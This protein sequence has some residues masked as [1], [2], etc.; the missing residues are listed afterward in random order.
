LSPFR[1]EKNP[2]FSVYADDTRFHDY[3]TG[4]DGDVFDFYRLGV[5]CAARESFLALKEMVGGK[6][7]NARPI[8]PACPEERKE[9]YHPELTKPTEAD[10]EA[11]SSLRLISVIGLDI[12][13][14][15]GFLWT[16]TIKG[17][18]AFVV[19]DRTRKNYRARRMDGE[20]WEHIGKKAYCLLE[21]RQDGR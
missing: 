14:D 13:V 9:Q 15:R 1:D 6:L 4:D 2:S 10:L 12:A 11:I 18:R 16:A 3:A 8:R 7:F 20:L 21:V 17:E 5:G 19:T